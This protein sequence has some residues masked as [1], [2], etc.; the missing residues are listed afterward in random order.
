MTSGAMSRV[1]SRATCRG[2]QTRGVVEV[3]DDELRDASK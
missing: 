1:T 2:T 3:V